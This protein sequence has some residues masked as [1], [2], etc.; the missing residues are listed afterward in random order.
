MALAKKASIEQIL[1]LYD[2]LS[3]EDQ[4]ELRRTFV[5][6]QDDIKIADERMK[7]SER[8]WTLDEVEKELGLAN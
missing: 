7:N 6:D 2:A 1:R 8:Q 4:A 5:E 3:P